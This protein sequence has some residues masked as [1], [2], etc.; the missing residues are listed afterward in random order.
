[1]RS[2]LILSLL[3]FCG[4]TQAQTNTATTITKKPKVVD[5]LQ[6]SFIRHSVIATLAV[7]FADGHRNDFSVPSGF[8]KN[9]TSGFAPVYGKLEYGISNNMSVGVLL[10][11]DGYMGN[12]YQLYTAN[13][14]DYKR[15]RSDKTDIYSAGLSA[16]YHFGKIIPVKRL[17]VFVGVGFTLNNEHHSALP[18]GDS[19]VKLTDRNVTPT[20]KAGVRYYLA[21]RSSLYADLGYDKNSMFCVGYSCRFM[22]K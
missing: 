16:N 11:Y 20:L 15:N 1:M 7:G 17:D 8:E 18:Q 14:K 2:Q 5:T 6:P 13:G 9:N 19:T 10:G 21:S 12:Y 4:V 3:L 22:K